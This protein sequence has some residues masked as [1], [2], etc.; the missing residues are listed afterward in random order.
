MLVERTQ[1]QSQNQSQPGNRSG[2]GRTSAAPD[3]LPA[4]EGIRSAPPGVAVF[5]E[6]TSM[7]EKTGGVDERVGSP[8]DEKMPEP[9]SPT[10]RGLG[11]GKRREEK[12]SD[13]IG[14]LDA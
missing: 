5:E 3:A 2:F 13:G 1:N 11:K 14:R 10:K 4:L 12:G 8:V 9:R 7:S 6:G